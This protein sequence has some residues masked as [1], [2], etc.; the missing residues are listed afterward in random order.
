[1]AGLGTLSLGRYMQSMVAVTSPGVS[2]ALSGGCGLPIPKMPFLL[3][4]LAQ[5]WDP[6]GNAGPGQACHPAQE[7][8]PDPSGSV[9]SRRSCCPARSVPGLPL[10]CRGARWG[11]RTC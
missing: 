5:Q 1:M 7:E 11:G 2:W 4:V 3:Q 10:P 8:Q 6:L 9:G